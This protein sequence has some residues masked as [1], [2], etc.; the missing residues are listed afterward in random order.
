MATMFLLHKGEDVLRGANRHSTEVRRKEKPTGGG[1]KIMAKKCK[2][3]GDWSL[4]TDYR[5]Q[6]NTALITKI[7]YL[8][9]VA[10]RQPPVVSKYAGFCISTRASNLSEIDCMR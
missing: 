7:V 8:S 5:E 2:I 1:L 10:N 3:T 4:I 6:I 9:S